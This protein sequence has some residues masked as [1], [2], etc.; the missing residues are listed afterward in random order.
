MWNLRK[1]AGSVFWL[2]LVSCLPTASSFAE[3]ASEDISR[4]EYRNPSGIK[5]DDD[6]NPVD[7]TVYPW[8]SIGRLNKNGSFCT[9][10]LIGENLV[11]TAAHCFW[12]RRTGRWS[13]ADQ[14]RFVVGYQKGH[15]SAVAKGS[16]FVTAFKTLPNLR[17]RTLNREDDWALLTID[18]PLG[19]TYGT[20]PLSQSAA[21]LFL[22]RKDGHVLQAGYSRD[23]A[24][25]LTVHEPCRLTDY[26]RINNNPQPVYF[27]QCDATKGDSGS[28]ILFMKDGKY[29]VVALH[30]ATTRR[31]SGQVVGIAVPAEYFHTGRRRQ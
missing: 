7:A 4:Y 27:H 22:N 13:S 26:V 20:V 8:S 21:A 5:G 9:G 11:L 15:Y 3:P 17:E 12:N 16:S 10:I 23:F 29:E 31:Q 2:L 1:S 6:R 30:S 18:K 19:R 24:H 28:P 25:V 14:Y